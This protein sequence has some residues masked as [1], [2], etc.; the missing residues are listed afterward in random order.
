[1][2]ELIFLRAFGDLCVCF[3]I[4][5][6][7]P[8][9]FVRDVLL[10]IPALLC[11]AGA[12]LGPWLEK[13]KLK[14]AALILPLASLL[15]ADSAMEYLILVPAIVYT[16]LLIHWGAFGM[17]YYNS[18]DQ[19]KKVGL[20]LGVFVGLLFPLGYF[21]GMY[22][23]YWDTYDFPTALF[24]GLLYAFTQV[25]LLRQLRLGVDSRPQDRLRNNVEMVVVMVLIIGATVGILALEGLL[26]QS[27]V[28]LLTL[29][30]MAVG[31]VPMLILEIINRFLNDE[32]GQAYVETMESLQETW[33]R[34]EEV[35]PDLEGMPVQPE[36]PGFPWLA[37][38]L[39]LVLL[40]LGAAYLL[41]NLGKNTAG[42]GSGDMLEAVEA[43][44]PGARESWS[45]NRSKVRRIYRS[46]LKFLR[47][48][49]QRLRHDQTSLDILREAKGPADPA[50]EL[51][52]IYVRAR[53]DLDEPV[54]DLD[55]EDAR[56][57]LKQIQNNA[58][59]A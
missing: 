23:Q 5:A 11:A 54:T 13:R 31:F 8:K 17:E 42:R 16:A 29:V 43:E 57:A 19:F 32:D 36:E 26:R 21:D 58:G 48:K 27:V 56:N 25:F 14:Y 34:G 15:L 28:D 47:R 35:V 20:A 18:R 1:M 2:S 3:A 24:Y 9:L 44:K 41:R 39:I 38:V 4:I 10:L 49:G 30:M 59:R 51:R 22:S 50:G 55:V 52:R 33:I 37:A 40:C 6:G 12:A 7:F 53:Y 46:Y 45:S